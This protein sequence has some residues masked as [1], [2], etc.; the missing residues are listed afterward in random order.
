MVPGAFVVGSAGDPT[1]PLEPGVLA[2]YRALWDT[3]ET[4]I[5]N[6]YD[7]D[8][9]ASLMASQAD[10]EKTLQMNSD[11]LLNQNEA[12]FNALLEQVKATNKGLLNLQEQIKKT[13]GTIATYGKV[14]GGIEKVLTVAG[15]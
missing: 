10:V 15:I 12:G 5:E 6:T 1:I 9:R 7:P 2:A 3:Y 14:L 8:L 4:A 13:A 11:Y